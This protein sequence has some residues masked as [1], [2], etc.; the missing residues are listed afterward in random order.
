MMITSYF[1][2]DYEK[3]LQYY[4]PKTI[5]SYTNY[6]KQFKFPIGIKGNIKNSKNYRSDANQKPSLLQSVQPL[7]TNTLTH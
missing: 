4:M 5:T 6:K 2:S 7:H 3:D 1:K